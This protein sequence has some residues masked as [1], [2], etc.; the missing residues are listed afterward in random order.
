MRSV[1]ITCLKSVLVSKMLDAAK[2]MLHFLP[3][4]A[5]CLRHNARPT[6]HGSSTELVQLLLKHGLLSEDVL[7]AD[8]FVCAV[9]R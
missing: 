9:I 8:S 7:A 5:A 1:A 3:H 6:L 4:V 2:I